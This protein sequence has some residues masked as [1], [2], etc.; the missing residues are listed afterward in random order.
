M[1]DTQDRAIDVPMPNGEWLNIA[2]VG[3]MDHDGV[4]YWFGPESWANACVLRSAPDLLEA[5]EALAE[6]V[7]R[8]HRDG[9]IQRPRQSS[10]AYAAIAKAR[11]ELPA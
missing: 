1:I 2:T 11:G 8:M 6:Y 4:K 3:C 10:D 9:H 7:D 5:L